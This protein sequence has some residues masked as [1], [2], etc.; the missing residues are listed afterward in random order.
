MSDTLNLN[1]DGRVLYVGRDIPA[2][3]VIGSGGIQFETDI[4]TELEQNGLG[5]YYFSDNLPRGLTLSQ[6]TSTHPYGRITGA[7]QSTSPNPTSFVVFAQDKEGTLA[8]GTVI[9]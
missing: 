5:Y 4:T 6:P 1:S 7:F 3:A 9:Y 2:I 8:K